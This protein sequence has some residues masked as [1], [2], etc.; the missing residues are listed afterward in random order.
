MAETLCPS[1]GF[2]PID[3]DVDECPKCSTRFAA[4]PLFKRVRRA[5]GH[6]GRKDAQ[7]L[8]ATRTVLGGITSAVDAHPVP[9]AVVLALA[10]VAWVLRCV[11]FLSDHPQPTWPL[12]IAAAQM[13]VAMLLWVSAGPGKSLAQMLALAQIGV[14]YFAG[15]SAVTQLGYAGV[16]VALLAMTMAEPGHTR[17]LV[18]TG[19]AV[20]MMGFGLWGVA[21][22]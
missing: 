9:T 7:D 18:S 4:N 1:C 5:G 20:A 15:G 22:G 2:G 11:G 12:Y 3:D 16:G 13:G 8:E 19:A 21:S 10:T 17:R 6:G 14:G